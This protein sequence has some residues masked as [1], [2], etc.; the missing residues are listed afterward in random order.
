MDISRFCLG[1]LCN[2][3]L[4]IYFYEHLYKLQSLLQFPFVFANK[5]PGK[6]LKNP[7]NNSNNLL[8]LRYIFLFYI[9]SGMPDL[10]M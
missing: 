8:E 2:Q 5:N 10:K 7:G 6:K 3:K 9:S 1:L 4:F